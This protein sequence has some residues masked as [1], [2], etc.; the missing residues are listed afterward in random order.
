MSW[1]LNHQSGHWGS[2]ELPGWWVHW[3]HRRMTCPDFTEKGMKAMCSGPSQIFLYMSFYLISPGLYLYNKNVLMSFAP[4]R[5]LRI[6]LQIIESNRD[7]REPLEFV[8]CVQKCCWGPHLCLMSKV[9][10]V[11]LGNM[12]LNL[13]FHI[14]DH[15]L[16]P[17]LICSI[18]V[19]VEMSVRH[20][21]C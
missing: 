7:S 5:V 17:K 19:S 10:A 13:Q 1:N 15:W 14:I 18:P 8:V 6:A 16:V 20:R 21:D 2:E 11:L 4:S 12:P 3:C 9:K